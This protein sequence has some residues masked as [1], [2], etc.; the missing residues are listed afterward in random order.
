MAKKQE[1]EAGAEAVA[2]ISAKIIRADGTEEDLGII[3]GVSNTEIKSVL[4]VLE[5]IADNHKSDDDAATLAEERNKEE[6]ERNEAAN[7]AAIAEAQGA[8]S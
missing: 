6:S 5:P 3:S 1:T 8:E 4:E 7:K 2:T